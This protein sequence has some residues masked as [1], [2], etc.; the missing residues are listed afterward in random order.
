MNERW[1]LVPAQPTEKMTL[2]GVYGGCE[3]AATYRQMIAARP[4]VSPEWLEAAV[5]RG[6]RSV[7]IA[8]TYKPEPACSAICAGC[9]KDARAAI[10]AALELPDDPQS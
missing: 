2:N 7:C 3:D 1:V 8:Q 6:A 4:P 9:A 5:E 10:L